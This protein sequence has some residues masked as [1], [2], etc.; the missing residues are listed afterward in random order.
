MMVNRLM[1]KFART[2]GRWKTSWSAGRRNFHLRDK[3]LDVL[4]V[5][6]ETESTENQ[7]IW[8]AARSELM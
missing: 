4:V 2:Y 3:L 6:K 7:E 8:R 1:Y 5:F